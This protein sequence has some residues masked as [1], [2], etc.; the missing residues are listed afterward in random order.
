[1][2]TQKHLNTGGKKGAGLSNKD[3]TLLVWPFVILIPPPL[4]ATAFRLQSFHPV[5]TVFMYDH[6]TCEAYFITTDGYGIFSVRTYSG[7]GSTYEGGGGQ[8][9]TSLHNS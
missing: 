2:K 5:H 8:A 1:M 9:Q 4:G 3:D 6:T 7:A